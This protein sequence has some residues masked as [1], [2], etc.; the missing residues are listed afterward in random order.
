[1]TAFVAVHNTLAVGAIRA[2]TDLGRRIPEDCSILGVAI[3]KPDLIIPPLTS[4]DFDINDVGRQA[5]HMLIDQLKAEGGAAQQVLIRP[6]LRLR[7]TTS[8]VP[9]VGK[10]VPGVEIHGKRGSYG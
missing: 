7:R 2:L 4:L 10:K 8:D 9:E 3:G 6:T 5:A 1:L